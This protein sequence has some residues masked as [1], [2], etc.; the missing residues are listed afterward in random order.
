MSGEKETITITLPKHLADILRDVDRLIGNDDLGQMLAESCG[1]RL[2]N[3]T[4]TKNDELFECIEEK[5]WRSK[6]EC[7]KALALI[8]EKFKGRFV[9][10]DKAKKGWRI[11]ILSVRWYA[12]WK[13]CHAEGLDY[14]EACEHSTN[15]RW[16]VQR[17][18]KP[19]E[20]SKP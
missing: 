14:D 10:M 7:E 13:Y 9:R 8:A 19:Y 2:E 5:R 16:A 4:E 3:F 20:L 11:R 18:L 6:S 12:L 1:W 15:T 17:I